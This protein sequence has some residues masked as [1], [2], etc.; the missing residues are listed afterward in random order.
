MAALMCGTKR[1]FEHVSPSPLVWKRVRYNSSSPSPINT[2]LP[3]I[4]N[5]NAAT[6][7]PASPEEPDS[8]NGVAAAKNG[9]EWTDSLIK[10]LLAATSV[11][12]AMV[13][14]TGV[15][16]EFERT[17]GAR[18]SAHHNKEIMALKEQVE[19][20]TQENAIV[21]RAVVIQHERQKEYENKDRELQHLKE[22]LVPQYK[23]Q[24]RTMEVNNYALSMHLKQACQNRSIPGEFHP[25]VF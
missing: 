15:L 17:V 11:D 5:S 2:Q 7:N 6:E 18:V 16:E 25:H 21:K 22:E 1:N 10:K 24:L 4:N 3:Y 20:L 8:K 13:C 23:E 9:V 19:R 12:E 14:T